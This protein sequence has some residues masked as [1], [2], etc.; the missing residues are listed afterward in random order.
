MGNDNWDGDRL[1]QAPT[2]F[3]A[4]KIPG[5]GRTNDYSARPEEFS[6]DL[7]QVLGRLAEPLEFFVKRF[8]LR[9]MHRGQAQIFESAPYLAHGLS[10]N[11]RVKNQTV[12]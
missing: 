2:S 12:L 8:D 11:F 9:H 3:R 1:L 4:F 10:G 6:Y 5:G 7:S